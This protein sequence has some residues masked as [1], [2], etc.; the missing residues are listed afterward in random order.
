MVKKMNQIRRDNLLKLLGRY[1]SDSDFC[2]HADIA[3]GYLSQLK[4]GGKP[5]GE[6]RN[7]GEKVA[8]K[9]ELA[10]GLEN[11]WLDRCDS[12]GQSS[13]KQNKKVDLDKIR[14]ERAL[15]QLSEEQIKKLVIPFLENLNS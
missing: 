13:I 8:R 11:G 4:M 12:A 14:V 3:A 5:I 1:E 2:L 6:G 9:I 15:S 7:I 10:V